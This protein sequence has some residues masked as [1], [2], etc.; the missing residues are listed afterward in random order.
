[1]SVLDSTEVLDVA[2]Y[3]AAVRRSLA[4]LG[5]DQVDDLTDD[6]EADLADALADER[7]NAHGRGV[8]EQFG[9]PEEYAAELRAA[10]GLLPMAA[11]ER[12]PLREL[13]GAPKASLLRLLGHLREER[14]WPPV[15]GFL[16]SIRPF[17]WLVRAWVGYQVAMFFLGF[18]S[19]LPESVPAFVFLAVLVVLSVQWGRGTWFRSGAMHGLAVV[20][21]LLAIVTVLP[22]TFGLQMQTD[23]WENAYHGGASSTGPEVPSN[24]V[25]VDGEPVGNIFA[26]DADGNPLT[27]VQL[28]DE[29]G[30]PIRTESYYDSAP[31]WD[32]GGRETWQLLSRTDADG[33]TRWNAFPLSGAPMADLESDV[34]GEWQLRAGA[35]A[36]TPPPPFAKAPALETAADT[37]ADTTVPTPSAS[38]PAPA[39]TDAVV[40]PV[41]AP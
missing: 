24:G 39:A 1:M 38:A 37:E 20:A 23:S 33:R 40:P 13:A 5:P 9:P 41:T 22:V 17:W 29:L 34:N 25:L 14:W 28:F 16:V 3:A 8:L 31:V 15:E 32:P 4:D 19:W 26:Y 30:R 6:L 35:T 11:P 21:N 2:G 12:R 36:K 27:D 10:A 18:Q 7:H